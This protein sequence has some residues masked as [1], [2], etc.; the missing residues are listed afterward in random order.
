MREYPN[1]SKIRKQAS[2]RNIRENS[3]VQKAAHGSVFKHTNSPPTHLPHAVSSGRAVPLATAAEL[4][5]MCPSTLPGSS[6]ACSLSSAQYQ[7]VLPGARLSC[8]VG[9]AACPGSPS[10]GRAFMSA[11]WNKTSGL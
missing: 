2:G 5:L 8:V 9:E 6:C 4:T 7:P 10:A 3:S 1:S 11:L